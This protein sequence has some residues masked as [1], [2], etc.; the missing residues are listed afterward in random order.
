VGELSR[1]ITDLRMESGG[2]SPPRSGGRQLT[3]LQ[4]RLAPPNSGLQQPP[5]R[6][7][8]STT[9]SSY[10]GSM[11]S[12]QIS[13]RSSQAS[14]VLVCLLL[15]IPPNWHCLTHNI[16]AYRCLPCPHVFLAWLPPRHSTTRSL[17][18]ALDVPVSSVDSQS[19]TV[20]W[21]FRRKTCHSDNGNNN[22]LDL[23]LRVT[24]RP[25]CCNQAAR[26][27]VCPSLRVL[28]NNRSRN[29]VCC[30]LLWDVTRLRPRVRPHR[31]HCILTRLWYW[32]R[33]PR[34]R[35]WKTNS[36]CQTRCFTSSV[37]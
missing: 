11:G 10:Y 6:D 30:C 34:A 2:N 4:V 33:S 9:V 35:W 5:R 15:S 18:V 26:L 37:R 31:A 27:V 23:R 21:W 14:Q 25:V 20:I 24:C 3:E 22:L 1:R 17:R 7:S 8:G 32:T 12:S 36:C 16:I 29:N 28:C 13:R 19:R